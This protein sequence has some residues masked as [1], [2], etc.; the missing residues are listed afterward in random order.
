MI[1]HVGDHALHRLAVGAHDRRPE[2][3]RQ[4]LRLHSVQVR[5]VGDAF[6]VQHDVLQRV[7][8]VVGQMAHQAAQLLQP[9]L[10]LVDLV[11]L[12]TS[13]MMSIDTMTCDMVTMMTDATMPNIRFSVFSAQFFNPNNGHILHM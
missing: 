2:H 5:G 7:V 10:W 1:V 12:F 3:D 13:D 11:G 9:A 4:V 8:V 6:Q